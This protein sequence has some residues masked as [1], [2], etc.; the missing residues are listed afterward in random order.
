MFEGLLRT[1][2]LLAFICRLDDV[3][4]NVL[5]FFWLV[6]ICSGDLVILAL[7]VLKGIV[8]VL[9][10]VLFFGIKGDGI[11]W[12]LIE[13]I[14]EEGF[15]KRVV[16]FMVGVLLFDN[17]VVFEFAFVSLILWRLNVRELIGFIIYCYC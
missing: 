5:L 6:D 1:E 12:T 11:F 16:L 4:L 14:M 7:Y 2:G 17:V 13:F 15:C 3:V 9:L 10:I 8:L